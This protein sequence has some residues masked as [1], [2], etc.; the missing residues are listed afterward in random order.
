[1]NKKVRKLSESK[2]SKE[3]SV[4]D[5]IERQII[6]I[7][8]S[9]ISEDWQGWGEKDRTE[10]IKKN[11]GSIGQQYKEEGWSVWAGGCTYREHGEW[12]FDMTWLQYSDK[13]LL[14]V[15]LVLESE[16]ERSIDDIMDDFQKMLLAKAD[17]RVMIFRA[18]TEKKGIDIIEELIK[19]VETFHHTEP[20]DRYLFAFWC[21]ETTK[22]IC[23]P[24]TFG[25]LS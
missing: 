24:Y 4:S 10:Y 18:K 20:C 9:T 11:I 12:L 3:M 21:D 1:M 19:Q 13:F 8:E 22:F 7:L 6:Q 17:H 15:P 23:R 14:S 16:W 5:E 25:S 2:V